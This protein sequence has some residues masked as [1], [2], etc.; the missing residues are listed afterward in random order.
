MIILVLI[1]P[2]PYSRRSARMAKRQRVMVLMTQE[3]HLDT[4]LRSE[5]SLKW[6]QWKKAKDDLITFWIF[7]PVAS[8][9]LEEDVSLARKKINQAL[10][11]DT[12][13]E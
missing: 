11:S 5:P 12:K 7:C 1:G 10:Q 9:Q 8:V 4:P 2:F 13:L 6:L 3:A